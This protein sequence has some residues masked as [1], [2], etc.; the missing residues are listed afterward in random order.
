MISNMLMMND[1]KTELLIVW[2]KQQLERVNLPF[3]HVGEDQIT[4]MVSV[5]NLGVIF[6]QLSSGYANH[7]YNI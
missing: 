1:N 4:H 6:T 5:R 2:N 7:L 3:I